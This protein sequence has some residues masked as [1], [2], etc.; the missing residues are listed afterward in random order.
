MYSTVLSKI[1]R[2]APRLASRFG[3]TGMNSATWASGALL[4]L[5]LQQCFGYDAVQSKPGA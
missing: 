3:T 1:P 5:S 4:V 2:T